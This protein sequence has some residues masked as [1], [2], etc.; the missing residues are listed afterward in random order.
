MRLLDSLKTLGDENAALLKE[1]EGAQEAR[2]EVKAVR[3]QMKSFKAEYGKRFTRLKAALDKVRKENGTGDTG[4]NPI[5]SSEY[6][7]SKVSADIKKK[8]QMIQKLAVDLRK[9][10]EESKKKD[11]ALRK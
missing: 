1:V 11:I 7:A 8:D 10:R 3:T 4:D 6:M 5:N 9:E 2:L